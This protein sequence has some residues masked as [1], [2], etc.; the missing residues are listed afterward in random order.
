[1][2]D[3]VADDLRRELGSFQIAQTAAGNQVIEVSASGHHG[4]MVI[5][6]ALALCKAV[7][8]RP[9]RTAVVPLAGMF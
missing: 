5:A 1:L 9:D 7:L 8:G 3:R 2:A 6:V 4:D